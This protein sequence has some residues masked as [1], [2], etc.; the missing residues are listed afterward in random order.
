MNALTWVRRA[1]IVGLCIAYVALVPRS[2]SAREKATRYRTFSISIENPDDPVG[3]RQL[4]RANLFI[5][6]NWLAHRKARANVTFYST[7]AGVTFTATVR[8]SPSGRWQV[9]E[10]WRQYHA[11]QEHEQPLVWVHTVFRLHAVRSHRVGFSVRLV[12]STGKE[13]RLFDIANWP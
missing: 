11:P 3:R 10:Y 7:D 12:S 4:E 1:V 2:V 6:S 9:D 5:W 13:S 8:R